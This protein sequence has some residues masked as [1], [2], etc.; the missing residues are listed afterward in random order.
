MF[1]L[2]SCNPGEP[3]LA[4]AQ[5]SGSFS[6]SVPFVHAEPVAAPRL[7][8][9]D[10]FRP[11]RHGCL[12]FAWPGVKFMPTYRELCEFPRA[13]CPSRRPACS[14]LSVPHCVHRKTR[15]TSQL[16]QLRLNIS[17]KIAIIL[18]P[19][20]VRISHATTRRVFGRPLGSQCLRGA[21]NREPEICRAALPH[22]A[23]SS[24][25]RMRKNGA[26]LST[27]VRRPP[28]SPCPHRPPCLRPAP[29]L[30]CTIKG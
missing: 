21:A 23:I 22:S 8:G 19:M 7:A 16:P 10:A 9:G 12:C 4:C 25:L 24:R 29:T 20:R 30:H 3:V 1:A 18:P 5:Q 28:S 11:D 13:Y 17:D 14:R 26:A 6:P 27:N 15:H 2:C